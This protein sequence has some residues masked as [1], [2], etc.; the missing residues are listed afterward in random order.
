MSYVLPV[1]LAQA[2]VTSLADV[3]IHP[4]TKKQQNHVAL[5][6]SVPVGTPVFAASS[7]VVESVQPVPADNPKATSAGNAIIIKEDGRGLYAC[8]FHLSR[9]DVRVGQRVVQG[10]QIGLSG[11]TGSMTTGPHLHW[12][13]REDRAGTKKIDPLTLLPQ[14]VS[15]PLKAGGFVRGNAASGGGLLLLAALGGWVWWRKKK[16]RSVLPWK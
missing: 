11:N 16:G 15:L 14:S 7:G 4:V 1:P 6:I 9:I 5:D 10:Q 8:Y 3:R 13:V 2:V 12:E